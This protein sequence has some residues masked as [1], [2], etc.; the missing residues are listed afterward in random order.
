MYK[1][2]LVDD[3]P[4]ILAGLKRSFNWNEM[5]FEVVGG[6]INPLEALEFIKNSRPD[7]VF[8]DIRMPEI[9]GLDIIKSVREYGLDTEFVII[10]GYSEFSY[11]QEAIK[12]GGV[13]D[14]ILKPLQIDRTD[15]ILKKILKCLNEKSSVKALEANEKLLK[16]KLDIYQIPEITDSNRTL[17]EGQINS[18]FKNLIEYINENYKQKLYITQLAKKFYFNPTYCCEL[19]KKFTGLTF[20][21]YLTEL[22]MKKSVELLEKTSMKI[23]DIAAEAGYSD[24]YY[25][26]R[27]FKKRFN[28]SPGKYRK[29]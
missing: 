16:C 25:F 20:S 15:E 14:Y 10:S 26:N 29:D 8:V 22:R 23:E 18:N 5:G 24:C 17:F 12:I 9:S 27:A 7:A 1:V 2:L 11:A 19:F 6:M 13:Q 3:E 28:I 4:W 21:E